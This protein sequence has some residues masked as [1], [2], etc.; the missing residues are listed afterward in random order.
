MLPSDE[1]NRSSCFCSAARDNLHLG[2]AQSRLH[3]S[4][5]EAKWR[6]RRHTLEHRHK[7]T[8]YENKQT[9]THTYTP[10]YSL[11]DKTYI[12]ITDKDQFF[13][14]GITSCCSTDS[15]RQHCCCHLKNKVD[16]IKRMADTPYNLQ[17]TGK[18]P[19][20]CPIPWGIQAPLNTRFLRL[21]QVNTPKGTST[22]LAILA[23]LMVVTN[24]QI[25]TTKNW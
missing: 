8:V 7:L 10:W 19:Q 15:K 4:G 25:Q 18:R 1:I 16:N 24:R 20:Y 5:S 23:Q 17:W 22:G 11:H 14:T 2:H 3:S 21:T 6:Q 9:Q 13:V 12:R